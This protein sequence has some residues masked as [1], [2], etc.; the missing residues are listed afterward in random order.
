MNKKLQFLFALT[1]LASLA[2]VTTHGS[3]NTVEVCCNPCCDK[4]DCHYNC[5]ECCM[6]QCDGYPFF[7]IRSQGRDSARE[8]VG[9]QQFVNKYCMED[10]YRVFSV[11]VEYSR[12]FRPERI[13]HFLFGNDLTNNCCE[14]LIQGNTPCGQVPD[15]GGP[16]TDNPKAWFANY[17]GLPVDYSSKVSFCPK[18]QNVVV[19]LNFY[20]G[21]DDISEGLYVRLNAP[22]VWTKW[23]LCMCEKI[24]CTGE[25]NLPAGYMAETEL[26]R[27]TEMVPTFAQYMAGGYTFGDM[28]EPMRYG[29]INNCPRSKT[30]LGEVDLSI[31]YNFRSE[32]DHHCG[33]SLYIAAPAG[34]RPCARYLFEPIVGN[35]KHWELGVGFSSSYIFWRSKEY[36]DR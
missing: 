16:A 30:R 12:S 21:L 29:L 22:I 5:N 1:I 27:Q 11:A 19:D 10:K 28:K 15:V 31:G 18:I 26:D 35:G 7:Q 24:L 23:E 34:N 13:A 3:G 9:W 8:L 25:D 4:Y 20:W 14:L 2:A 17:F 6:G 36:D 32:E 33:M